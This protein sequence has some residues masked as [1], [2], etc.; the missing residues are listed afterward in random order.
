MPSVANLGLPDDF[1]SLDEGADVGLKDGLATS[2]FQLTIDCQHGQ[3]G[4][5]WIHESG[6]MQ[7]CEFTPAEFGEWDGARLG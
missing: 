1:A 5:K 4:T 3:R 6:G 2:V 7:D